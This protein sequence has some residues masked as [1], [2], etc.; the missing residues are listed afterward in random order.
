MATQLRFDVTALDQ[1]SKAFARMGAAVERFERKLDE[2]DGKTLDVDVDLNTR[3]AEAEIGKFATDTR[4]KLDAALKALPDIKLDADSSDAQ[5]EIERIRNEMLALRDQKIGV[6]I[7]SAKAVAEITRM[8]G[9]LERLSHDS[10]DIQI[11]ADA[12]SAIAQLTAVEAAVSALD[13]QTAEV[14]LDVD[15]VPVEAATEALSNMVGMTEAVAAAWPPVSAGILAV[16]GALALVAAPLAAI[17]VGMDGIAGA[18]AALQPRFMSLQTAVQAAFVTGLAP[19]VANLSKLFPTLQ[20]GMTGTAT[21]LSQIASR[22]AA[23]VSSSSGLSAMQNIFSGVNTA[24]AGLAPAFATLTANVLKLT[25]AGLQGLQPLGAILEEV[26]QRWSAMIDGL[27]ASGTAQAAVSSLVQAFGAVLDIMPGLVS[28]GAQLMAVLGPPLVAALTA[29]ANVVGFLAGPLGGVTTAVLAA[30]AAFKVLSV[31]TALIATG[32]A[33]VGSAWSGLTAVYAGSAGAARG[34]AAAGTAAAGAAAAT[35]AA[36]RGAA[37]GVSILQAY[38]AGAAGASTSAASSASKFSGALSKMGAAIP[39]VGAVLVGLSLV[40]QNTGA[41]FEGLTQKVASGALSLGQAMQQ[42]GDQATSGFTGVVNWLEGDSDAAVT[43]MEEMK[44]SVDDYRAS[45]SPMGQLQFDVARAQ[46]ELNDAVVKFGANTPEAAAAARTLADAQGKLATAQRDATLAASNVGSSFAAAVTY[47]QGAGAAADDAAQSAK[48][49]A[50]AYTMLAN[51][52]ASVTDQA[53]AFSAVFANAV[54]PAVLGAEAL[55]GYND[56]MRDLAD[57]VTPVTTKLIALDGTIN[58]TTESGSQLQA[59]VIATG[60]AMGD[61]ASAMIATEKSTKGVVVA[62]AEAAA[63][64]EKQKQS[65]ID[66]MVKQGAARPAAEALANTFMTFP[67]D[68][69]TTF[70]QPGMVQ[71]ITESMGLKSSITSIP[72]SKSVTI[73]APTETTIKQLQDLG[74]EIVRIPGTKDV[75]VRAKGDTTNLYE[76][77][78]KAQ[79]DLGVPIPVPLTGDPSKLNSTV[80][81]AVGEIEG[82]N[83]NVPVGAETSSLT[84][85]VNSS[86]KEL[87]NNTVKLPVD[88]NPALLHSTVNSSVNDISGTTVRMHLDAE[89]AGLHS[90]VNSSIQEVEGKNPKMHIGADPSQLNSTVNSTK[91]GIESNPATMPVGADATSLNAT[92]NSSRAEVVVPQTMPLAGDPS[93]LNSTINSSRADAQTTSTMPLAGNPAQL[94]STIN[95]SRADAQTTSTMPLAGNPAQLNATVNSAR[96]NAERTATMPISARDAGASSVAAAIRA[97]ISAIPAVINIVTRTATGQPATPAG[98]GVM[99]Y[100]GGGIARPIH[101][102]RGYVLP[103]YA[104]GRDTIPAILSAGEAVLVP[105]LVRAIGARRILAANREASGGRPA[106]N[107]G[108]IAALMDGSIRG[109]QDIGRTGGSSSVSTAMRTVRGSAAQQV[110]VVFNATFSSFIPTGSTEQRAAFSWLTEGIRKF[111]REGK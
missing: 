99:G 25:T 79:R 47:F 49:L 73:K 103:G 37:G 2:I 108:S 82:K 104:P 17:V 92:V 84:S 66:L 106:S 68:I 56:S 111:T 54:E 14:D 1:A 42:A 21:A 58:T 67:K 89:P 64:F 52:L 35:G 13:G 31:S 23:V 18:A 78:Q 38:T 81:A 40:A 95:S 110:Q 76:Q 87:T 109:A 57:A 39:V 43:A 6:D 44:K 48:L 30:A 45:L 36:A 97:S 59:S 12:G 4:R 10:A 72:D 53:G 105:E 55:R 86:V 91:A 19:A 62:T 96:G 5:R 102:R 11:K 22:V 98:G 16:P 8:R 70:T 24:V 75:L 7:E 77:I 34:A 69:S 27:V 20:T 100:A 65:V 26:G 74:L 29:V 85:T 71:A 46:G 3:K 93:Q 33:K 9:E 15:S 90:T 51:P 50:D 94:N 32:A 61:N 80:N 101:A 83:V 28:A 41:D 63:A 107:V 60:K 88:G